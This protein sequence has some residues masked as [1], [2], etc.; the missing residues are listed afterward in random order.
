MQ[1]AKL[2]IVT[3]PLLSWIFTG[4]QKLKLLLLLTVVATVII[5]VAPLEMQKRIVNQAIKLK[6]FDLLLI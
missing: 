5:R 2:S 6:A 4:N 3:K 1:K